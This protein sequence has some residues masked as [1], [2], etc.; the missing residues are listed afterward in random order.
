MRRL[1]RSNVRTL[2]TLALLTLVFLVVNT[3][4][5]QAADSGSGDFLSPLNVDTSEGAPVNGYALTADGGSIVAFTSQACAMALAGLFTLVQ[6]LVGLACWALEFAFR[7]PLLKLLADPAQEASDAYENAIVDT[8]GVKGLMLTWAFVFGLILFV[9]GKPGKG[10]GEIA[11]TL[12]IAAFAASAF[13]RPDYLLS[14]DGPLAKSQR[15]AAEVSQ[16]TSDSYDWGGSAVL[17]DDA[18]CAGMHGRALEQCLKKWD[19]QPVEAHAVAKPIQDATTNALIVKPYMLLQ[20]GR[21]LDPHRAADRKAYAVHLKWVSGGYSPGKNK[22]KGDDPCDL[23]DGPAKQYC[24]NGKAGAGGALPDLTPGDALLDTARP[25]VDEDDQQF[26][27]LLKDLE[28]SGEVGTACAA[29]AKKP[30]WW[31]VAGAALLLIAA[32][33]I[34]AI[35]LASTVVLLGTQAADAGAAA[36]GVIAFVWGMLPG[37][38]RAAVWK[39][40]ALFAV[41]I[42]VMFGVSMFLPIFGMAIDAVLTDGPDLAAERLLMLDVLA[43]M[44][45]VF[46]RWM[47]A[48]ITNFG[49]TM[50]IRMRFAKVGGT[51]LPGDTSEIGAALAMHSGAGYGSFALGGGLR[52]LIGAGGFGLGTRHRLFGHLAAMADGAGMPV[53]TQRMLGDGMA[54]AARGLAPLGLAAAG[55]RLGLRG[56]WGLAVGKRPDDAKLE[57]WRKPTAGGDTGTGAPN[58]P[59]VASPF[60]YRRGGPADRY[61]DSDGTI[62]NRNS[63]QL[64][65]DQ[66]TDPTL[67]S[68]RAHNHLVRLRGYRILHRTGRTAYNTT[69]GLP[70]TVRS[71]ARASS[72][73]S[74]DARQQLRVWG[75]TVREDGRQWQPVG[76]GIAAGARGIRRGVDHAGQRL[77]VAARVHGPDAARRARESARDSAVTAG[78]VFGGTG[79]PTTATGGRTTHSR[80]EDARTAN[81]R[82]ILDALMQAQ[83]ASMDP[84]PRWGRRDGDEE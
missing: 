12:L 77:D 46:H 39:W 84:P 8:L 63:G 25:V 6:V 40:L 55:A 45:L 36:G 72:Q 51:H 83:R 80:P 75:N 59:D 61:R 52:G 49:R 44:G 69:Y 24:E 79:P 1:D 29:Y 15:A 19:A 81:R 42:A 54:E 73:Y 64:L 60:A 74:Q 14:T 82:R 21:T 67:L 56:A 10:L 66:N 57:K 76:H 23:I 9:R 17:D 20:Y 13:V 70:A 37:P 33:L 11:L 34:C 53:D 2:G 18:R 5:A 38:N 3:S 50:A 26:A 43:F 58:S 62:A 71:G 78:L 16:Q 30:T 68:T 65:H 27:A 28:K 32:L 48:K 31:R 7:F 47:L 4:V 22:D 41:S 35:L